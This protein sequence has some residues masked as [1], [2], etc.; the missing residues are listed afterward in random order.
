MTHMR[1][2]EDPKIQQTLAELKALL[3]KLPEG[4]REALDSFLTQESA[5]R[6]FNG[7]EERQ[8]RHSNRS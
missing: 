1:L 3:G 7:K 6:D 2:E 8:G 5:R 4:R